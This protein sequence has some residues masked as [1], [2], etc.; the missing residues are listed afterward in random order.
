MLLSGSKYKISCYPIAKME[1]ELKTLK[2]C[3]ISDV[4]FLL[5]GSFR[6]MVILA[7]TT[8]RNMSHL[9]ASILADYVVIFFFQII[10]VTDIRSFLIYRKCCRYRKLGILL[11]YQDEHC[12]YLTSRACNKKGKKNCWSLYSVEP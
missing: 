8:V 12:L 6:K 1:P 3:P 9:E 7:P 10:N 4:G 5:R 2:A 11:S